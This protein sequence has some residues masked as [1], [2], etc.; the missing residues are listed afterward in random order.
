MRY[1]L[2]LAFPV[3]CSVHFQVDFGA[4]SHAF[5]CDAGFVEGV[6]KDG[7]FLIV[8]EKIQLHKSSAIEVQS[9]S[10]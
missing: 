9:H 7:D 4:F 5:I 1:F 6:M 3:V 8:I 2:V 10:E